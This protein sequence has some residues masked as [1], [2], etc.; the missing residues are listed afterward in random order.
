MDGT[1]RASAAGSTGHEGV[2]AGWE[3]AHVVR[4]NHSARSALLKR[5]FDL[6]PLLP[7]LL[8]VIA[9]VGMVVLAVV[10]LDLLPPRSVRIAAGAE[11]SGYHAVAEK[12]A[13]ILAEDDI[14]TV[15]LESAGSV[16]N[17]ALL[18]AGEADVALIQGGITLPQPNEVES[19]AAVFLEPVFV[20]HRPGVANA[21]D[22]AAWGGLRIAAGGPGS[23][24]RAAVEIA[25][26]T[27]DLAPSDR[28]LLPLGGADAAEAL[29][30]RD[31]DVAVFVAPID[32]PYLTPLLHDDA[33]RIAPIRDSEALSRRLA[34]VRMVDIPPAA[35]DYAERLPPERV[36][37]VAMVASL[38]ARQD[39]H[40]AL[41]DRLVRAAKRVHGGPDLVTGDL[42]FPTTGGIGI[43]A[44]AHAAAL[45][46]D[47]PS[48]LDR[49]LPYWINAQIS[50]IALLLVPVIVLSLPLIRVVPGIYAWRMHSR[51]YRRYGELVSIEREAQRGASGERRRWLLERLDAIDREAG[52]LR[53]PARYREYAYTFRLHI[54]L[55]RRKL[56]HERADSPSGDRGALSR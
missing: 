45:L 6:S 40:P 48:P 27:L 34:F 29:L 31:I 32:A 23:G 8:V 25:L 56:L 15:I 47:G 13:L 14:E 9:A 54:D 55:V 39:L 11:G 49:Y 5:V 17:A 12:Y 10:S 1:S 19:L 37:L 3:I 28:T 51:V 42:R 36:P 4:R 20:F 52:S 50:R 18:A 2:T 46:R 43:P 26:S 38:V 35:I 7:S 41:V 24:T 44:N 33:V 30:R 16:E 22:P 53:L 21:A